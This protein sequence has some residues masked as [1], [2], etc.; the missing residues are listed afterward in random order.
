MVR[1]A[2][3]FAVYDDINMRVKKDHTPAIILVE[4]ALGATSLPVMKAIIRIIRI[5]IIKN[6]GV[7]FLVYQKLPIARVMCSRSG[8]APNNTAY[9][10]KIVRVFF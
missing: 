10:F 3:R 4:L 6:T 8:Q 9:Q 5:R 2:A 1:K 7:V